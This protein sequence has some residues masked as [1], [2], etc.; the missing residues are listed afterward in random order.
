MLVAEFLAKLNAEVAV[1]TSLRLK[2]LWKAMV[3]AWKFGPIP[4][5]RMI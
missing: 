5:P 4:T 1:A 2:V 3:N